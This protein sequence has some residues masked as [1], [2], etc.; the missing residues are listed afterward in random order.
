[1]CKHGDTV[2]LLVPTPP[3]LSPTGEILWDMQPVDRCIAPIVEALN[4][5]GIHTW[6]SCCEHDWGGSDGGQITLHDGRTLGISAIRLTAAT[7]RAKKP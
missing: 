7:E 1:M 6:S 4:A 3:H 2:Q 5:A